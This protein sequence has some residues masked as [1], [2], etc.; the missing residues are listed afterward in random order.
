MKQISLADS[1]QVQSGPVDSIRHMTLDTLAQHTAD[2]TQEVA[3]VTGMKG[4]PLPYKIESDEAI[5]GALA[6]CFVFILIALQ[7]GSKSVILYL[8][9]AVTLRKRSNS[10]EEKV[11]VSSLSSAALSISTVLSSG[12]CLY[13]HYALSDFQT[14]VSHVLILTIYSLAFALLIE[15]KYL[16]YN[17]VNWVF[18]NREKSDLWRQNYWGLIAA[19]GVV[20]F[21]SVL[22]TVFLDSTIQISDY[23]LLM[24]LL[25]FKILLFYKLIGN[26]F[27]HFYGIL[28]LILYFCALE[29]IPDLFLWK[30]VEIFNNVFLKL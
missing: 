24:I 10:F 14:S 2:T 23:L 7:R 5:V 6:L 30:G 29:I 1:L 8:K 28:H 21:P 16:L 11:S 12:I 17:F 26:F 9:E 4:E 25:I 27:A 3:V 13:R 18:F 15:G 19:S 22:Y 20:L